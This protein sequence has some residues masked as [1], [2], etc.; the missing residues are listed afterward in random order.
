MLYRVIT[1]YRPLLTNFEND[2]AV[3]YGQLTHEAN[4][5]ALLL[6]KVMKAAEVR[7]DEMTVALNQPHSISEEEIYR[8]TR[9]PLV[10]PTDRLNSLMSEKVEPPIPLSTLDEKLSEL[11]RKLDIETA[12]S[13]KKSVVPSW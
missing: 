3:I 1:R 7:L 5:T 4:T 2:R 10:L 11:L 12:Q 13:K 9:G 6:R 8:R